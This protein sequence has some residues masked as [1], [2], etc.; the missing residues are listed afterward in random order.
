MYV[1]MDI[2]ELLRVPTGTSFVQFG[3]KVCGTRKF[4]AIP[5][6][7]KEYNRS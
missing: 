5:N 3:R 4:I 7:F 2:E 1:G 6:N